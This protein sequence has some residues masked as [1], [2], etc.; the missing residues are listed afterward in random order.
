MMNFEAH[1]REVIEDLEAEIKKQQ[2]LI[3]L[4]KSELEDNHSYDIDWWIERNFKG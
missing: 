4:L 2:R 1:D 3:E